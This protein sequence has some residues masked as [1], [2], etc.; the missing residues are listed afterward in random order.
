MSF[1]RVGV[2]VINLFTQSFVNKKIKESCRMFGNQIKC[3]E[4]KNFEHHYRIM[5]DGI[6]NFFNS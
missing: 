3:Y 5:S 6:C 4:L 1:F 2:K